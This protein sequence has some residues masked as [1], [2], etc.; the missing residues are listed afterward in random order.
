MAVQWRFP[1]G[2]RA[3]CWRETGGFVGAAFEPSNWFLTLLANREPCEG[4][5]RRLSYAQV[6]THL[7]I[8]FGAGEK[9]GSSVAYCNCRRE[10]QG[11][12]RVL[13]R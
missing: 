12:G 1:G 13:I 6:V 3:V 2:R 11:S 10:F 4:L 7:G 5:L 8:R 9:D